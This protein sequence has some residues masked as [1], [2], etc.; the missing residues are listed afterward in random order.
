MDAGSDPGARTG[1]VAGLAERLRAWRGLRQVRRRER[2]EVEHR[3]QRI[4]DGTIWRSGKGG[5]HQT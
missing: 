2:A 3:N 5:G 1:F 4:D